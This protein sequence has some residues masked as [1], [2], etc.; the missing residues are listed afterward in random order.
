M[1]NLLRF[2]I[3]GAWVE[4]LSKATLEVINPATE[5][6]FATIALGNKDDVDRAVKAARAA[7]PAFS[8]SSKADRL[9]LLKRILEIYN[10]RAEELAQVVCDEMGAPLQFARDAQVWAGRVHLEATIAALENYE[11]EEQ[12]GNTRVVREGIGVVGLITP[13][14]WPLNQIVCKVAPALAAGC[15]MVLKPSEIAPL[16]GIVFA[17]IMHAAKTPPGVFNL[18]NGDGP[19]VGQ[20]LALHPDVDMMSFTGSTRAGVMVAKSAA[21]TVKRVTQELGGKSA[22]IILPDADLEKAVRQ[23]VEACFSNTGQSC[24]APTRMLVPRAKLEAALAVAKQTADKHAVGNPRT[25]GTQLGPVVSAT[26]FAK[27]QRLIDSGIAE[28]ASLVTGGPGKPP[29]LERGYFVRPTVFGPVR[30][31]MTIAREEI[32][33][34]VLAIIPYDSEQQ[35]VDIANDT[36]YGLA[37]YVQSPNLDNARRVARQLRAGQVNLNYPDWDTAAPFGGYKQ[38]GN[39][40]EYADWGI[41]DFLEV[42]GIV[43]FGQE[44]GTT[45]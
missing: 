23:G 39:G 6:A 36:V 44:R 3:N 20:A 2:Y 12:R 8:Q 29:G 11:F 32:F 14:N 38:S 41:H 5:Q 42:K 34:P 7:F 43:G 26:Q 18:V 35:A 16:S 40:R 30:P 31:D 28:G 1:N 37:A 22:N 15:T 13:W 10:E 33:G 19:G 21:D 27:V 45:S 9:K 24:D 4:P 17:E 25:D